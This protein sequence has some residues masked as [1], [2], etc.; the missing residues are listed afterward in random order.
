MVSMGLVAVFL[1]CH[2]L[3]LSLDAHELLTLSSANEC[4]AAGRRG[5]PAWAIC[6]V[7]VSHLLLAVNSAVNLVSFPRQ[8]KKCKIFNLLRLALHVRMKSTNGCN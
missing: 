4:R 5:V 2:S 6:A 1:L 8:K 3:R 7:H